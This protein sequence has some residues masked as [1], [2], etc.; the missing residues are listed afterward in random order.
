MEHAV[1][2]CI[3][4]D[5]A[6]PETLLFEASCLARELNDPLS[7]VRIYPAGWDGPLKPHPSAWHLKTD[8]PAEAVRRFVARNR[9]TR[10]V[11]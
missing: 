4:V 7:V 9:I 3:P 10:V 11:C 8:A 1:L 2:V 5:A 6:D